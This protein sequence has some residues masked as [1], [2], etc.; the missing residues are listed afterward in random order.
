V[1]REQHAVSPAH[2]VAFWRAAGPERWF[3]KSDDFDRE[4]RNRFLVTHERAAAGELETW[5]G[6]SE[7]A[8]S[9]ILVLDQFPRN[10]FRGSAQAFA[11]D[12]RACDVA[13]AAIASE[14]DLDA[15]LALQPFIYLPFEHA[16][17]IGRQERAVE[18]MQGLVA[19]GGDTEALKWAI[20]HREII[21][22][23][24]RFPHRNSILGRQS[25][26]EEQAYLAEG[27]FAG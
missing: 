3:S 13:S 14:Q 2:V 12:E 5:R 10:I 6:S 22:R 7:G 25:T 9:L 27:G 15:E 24:G 19:R 26:P 18:L 11:T 23:F 8:L 17:D 21:K 16:E 4:I 1:K 20:D